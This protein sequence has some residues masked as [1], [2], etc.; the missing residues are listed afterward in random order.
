VLGFL[1]GVL[2]RVLAFPATIFICL[3]GIF[4]LGE[5]LLVIRYASI[6]YNLHFAPL[7]VLGLAAFIWTAAIRLKGK[8]RLLI[9]FLE[10]LYL[11]SQPVIQLSPIFSIN[12]NS[13]DVRYPYLQST[14]NHFN[15]V[16]EL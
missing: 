12:Q 2:T 13:T 15:V 7:V 4:S 9:L 6:H 14:R 10:C 3:F 5:W 8:Q 11:V 1:V 16:V